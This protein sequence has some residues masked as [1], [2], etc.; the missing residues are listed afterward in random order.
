MDK[1]N[2]QKNLSEKICGCRL[3]FFIKEYKTV[4]HESNVH[5]QWYQTFS[6]LDTNFIL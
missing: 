1:R 4:H 5:Q 6:K 3:K 2:Q